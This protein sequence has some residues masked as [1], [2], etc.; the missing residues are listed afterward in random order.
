MA[1][2]VSSDVLRQL[3]NNIPIEE[4]IAEVLYIPHKYTEGYF[5]FL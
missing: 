2:T 5:R 1:K 3:R 4:L